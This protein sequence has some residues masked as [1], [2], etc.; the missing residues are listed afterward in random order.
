VL[1]RARHSARRSSARQ[2]ERRWRLPAERAGLDALRMEAAHEGQHG[3]LAAAQMR[4]MPQRRQA[5]L[6]VKSGA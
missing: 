6:P 3:P 4:A 5:L 2:L 1:R